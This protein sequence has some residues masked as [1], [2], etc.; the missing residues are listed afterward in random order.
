ML[1]MLDPRRLRLLVE[2]AERDTISAVADA[3]HFT[4]S[5]VSHGLSALE[6]DVG[7]ALLERSPRSVRLTRAGAALATEARVLLA[8]LGA[9]EADARAVGRLERG[10]I[11]L[12]TFPSAGASIVADAV[13]RLR[14][15][16][17]GL[18]LRLLDAEP[19]ESVHALDAGEIDLAVIYEY[20]HL[21]GVNRAGSVAT[22]LLDDPIRVCLP[23]GYRDAVSLSDLRDEAFVAGRRGSDCHAFARAL[24]QAHG[25]EPRIA[26][27]TDDI[28]FTCALVNAGVGVAVMPALL[29][30]AAPEP[31][32]TQPLDV[33]P[34]RIFAVHRA[35]ASGLASVTATVGALAD[36]A[37][38]R[39]ST[40]SM[41]SACAFD[42]RDATRAPSLAS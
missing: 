2:L 7:V 36:A 21:P 23:P 25:F 15:R 24:C 11:V 31:V 18:A 4:P 40:P 34:R 1:S 27:E 12:A 6:R 37:A 10:E 32:A 20:P 16:H 41:A 30:S 17:P 13:V 28:A 42:G 26:F 22:P 9:A 5:T 35:T 39:C 38:A 19:A 14:Q 8:R 33:G 3:L 29:I